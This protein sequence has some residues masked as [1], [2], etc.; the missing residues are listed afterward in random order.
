MFVFL[1]LG[2]VILL[3]IVVVAV[4]SSVS[5]ITGIANEAA[6]GDAEE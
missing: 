1:F 2:G 6:K 5:V 4:V 3:S